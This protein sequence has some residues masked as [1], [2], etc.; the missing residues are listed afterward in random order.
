M[1]PTLT[2]IEHNPEFVT[3]FSRHFA[4]ELN[5]PISA[6][7]SSVYLIEDFIGSAKDGVLSIEEVQPFIE[8][9]HEESDAL[10]SLVQE[11][12]KFFSTNSI[13]PSPLDLTEFLSH[14]VDDM[15]RDGL[16]VS[17]DQSNEHK[18]IQG[19]AGALQLVLRTLVADAVEAGATSVQLSTNADGILIRD[20]RSGSTDESFFNKWSERFTSFGARPGLGLKLPLAAKIIALHNG[21]LDIRGAESGGVEVRI[22]LPSENAA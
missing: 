4:H 21:S 2:S 11:F 14:R 1:S 7:S 16:P 13:L 5:N 15:K 17:M 20:N 18:T 19:D 12:S 22:L 3:K 6:I 8:S 10:K 9:I